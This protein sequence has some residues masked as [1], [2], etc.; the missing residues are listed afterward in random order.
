MAVSSGRG[1]K[2]RTMSKPYEYFEVGEIFEYSPINHDD[3][4]VSP[5]LLR[6]TECTNGYRICVDCRL[7]E[8]CGA[9]WNQVQDD[10]GEWKSFTPVCIGSEREDNKTVH[11]KEL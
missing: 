5:I 3:I 11:F 8:W 1:K 9:P 4:D 2:L 6:V 7:Y 10:G